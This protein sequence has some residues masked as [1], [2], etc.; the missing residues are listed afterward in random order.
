M[1]YAEFLKEEYN[2]IAVAISGTTTAK[3]KVATFY[4]QKGEEKYT[5]LKLPVQRDDNGKPIIDKNY[6]YSENGYIPDWQF[7]EDYINS[8]PYSDRLC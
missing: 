1:Y 2:V 7:M 5:I 6:T 4:W 3:M 8:L